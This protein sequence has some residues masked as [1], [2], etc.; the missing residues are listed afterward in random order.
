VALS[1]LQSW[2][3]LRTNGLHSELHLPGPCLL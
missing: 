1:M 3:M 2:K